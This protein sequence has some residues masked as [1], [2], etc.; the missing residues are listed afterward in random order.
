MIYKKPRST[1][2]DTKFIDIF[3]VFFVTFVVKKKATQANKYRSLL[4]L[5]VAKAGTRVRYLIAD[6]PGKNGRSG[7]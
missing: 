5:N 3:F 1:R 2:S 7:R 6:C 4:N